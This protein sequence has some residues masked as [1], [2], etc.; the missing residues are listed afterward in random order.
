M[1]GET[2]SGWYT[3]HLKDRSGEPSGKTMLQVNGEALSRG[4]H[5]AVLQYS[6]SY[7]PSSDDAALELFVIIT[8]RRKSEDYIIVTTP[9]DDAYKF[10]VHSGGLIFDMQ[11]VAGNDKNS[12][13][14]ENSSDETNS[15]IA[16]L[17]DL[18][19]Q[20]DELKISQGSHYFTIKTAG[21]SR[22]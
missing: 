10:P 3:I 2:K 12:S 16:K 6:R 1:A 5:Q 14:E 21:F 15:S 17:V 22:K 11:E 4:L 20:Y 18:M 19:S 7:K 13:E 9:D 8:N